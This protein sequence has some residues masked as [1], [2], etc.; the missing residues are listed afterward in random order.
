METYSQSESSLYKFKEGLGAFIKKMPSLGRAYN[1]F[2]EI[3][4]QEEKLS[5]KE[6]QLI[7]LGISLHAQEGYCIIYHIKGCLDQWKSLK[8][9]VFQQLL[10]VVQ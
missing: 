5:K 8:Q 6:K 3:C 4:F 10:A 1:E 9:W 7:A 2:T